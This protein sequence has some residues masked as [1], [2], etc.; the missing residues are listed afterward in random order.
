M[1]YFNYGSISC[2]FSGIQ[3]R[4][5]SGS[6]NPGQGSKS[7]KV[8]PFNRLYNYGFLLVF[9]SHIVPEIFHFKHSVTLNTG[10]GIRQSHWKCH[11]SIERMLRPAEGVSLLI[12]YRRMESK[13]LQWWAAESNYRGKTSC[14][15]TSRLLTRGLSF[16]PT[17]SN[18]TRRH[19]FKFHWSIKK[20][21]FTK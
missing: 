18:F 3:C 21:F 2:R 20:L 13:K 6:W 19:V 5:I 16:Q 11:H 9:Y 12:G 17:P 15:V 10:L 14:A 4:K 8:V 1:F 7:L